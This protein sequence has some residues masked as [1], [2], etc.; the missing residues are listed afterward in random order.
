V[1]SLG[2]NLGLFFLFPPSAHTQTGH[3][4]VHNGW[5]MEEQDQSGSVM[6]SRA[7]W[8][9]KRTN[10]RSMSYRRAES[11][12]NTTERPNFLKN[13]TKERVE[14][15][16]NRS[17]CFSLP[18][19]YVLYSS[20]VF[21]VRCVTHRPSHGS[22]LYYTHRL[23]FVTILVSPGHFWLSSLFDFVKTRTHRPP[24]AN[25]PLIRS[26]LSIQSTLQWV[27]FC[28]QPPLLFPFFFRL[29]RFKG[30]P[31]NTGRTCWDIE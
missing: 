24:S 10:F 7:T 29:I 12:T 26:S 23:H 8:K 19:I 21:G 11:H 5:K 22:L 13:R 27:D 3:R 17:T 6:S 14:S 4:N 18:W 20:K 2:D 30:F 28:I 9:T 16:Q 31:C 25:I 1:F 15:N